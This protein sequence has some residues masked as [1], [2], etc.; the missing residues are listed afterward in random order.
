[1]K[2]ILYLAGLVAAIGLG[3][4]ARNLMPAG[5]PPPG[6]MGP[7]KMPPPAVTAQ[8]IKEMP[9]DLQDE[10]IGSIEPVQ[11]VMVCT[12]VAG[13]IEAVHF[14]EGTT[15][16]QGDLLFT[17]D[18]KQY[19]A[20]VEV[21]QAEL[22]RAEAELKRSEKYLKRM[23][24]A[25]ER[26][27]SESDIDKAESDNEQAVAN[28][29]QAKANLHLAQINLD[30]TEIRAPIDGQIG[31]AMVTKGN[32]VTSASPALARIVQTDP[33]RVVFSMTDRAYLNLRRQE[34]NGGTDKLA[35]RVRLPNGTMFKMVGTKNFDD[36]A[37]NTSTGT[38]AVRYIFD[39]PDRMLIPGGYVNI[40]LGKQERPM[41]IRV[42]QKAVMV[43]PKGNYVLTVNESGQ[44][45]TARVE[46]GNS[47]ETDFVA[48]SGLKT[49]DRV[50]VDGVQKVRPG[51][52]ANVSLQEAVK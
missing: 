49:G 20:M 32:Y 30:Y 19:R 11:E 42:P 9:L 43:D 39:N 7:G 3:F 16:N 50:I 47:I 2:K 45:G 6:M 36:N 33:I 31:A 5:G 44:V 1:M 52:T 8:E 28:L 34:L 22:A 41:G 29:Q 18:Q 38:L 10:Y 13:Y 25:S 26:S 24:K 27:V 14:K 37:M 23:L 35:A 51:A 17:I 15:V 48:L 40:L 21:R 4:F 46:L 12:E